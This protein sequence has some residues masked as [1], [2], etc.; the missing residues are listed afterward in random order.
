MGIMPSVI[1]TDK[2]TEF[3]A[4]A[5]VLLT[6]VSTIPGSWV[7][8]GLHGLEP[9]TVTRGPYERIRRRPS[10]LILRPPRE[11]GRNKQPQRCACRRAKFRTHQLQ[12]VLEN[13][14]RRKPRVRI[15]MRRDDITDLLAYLGEGD[16]Q[17]VR[18]VRDIVPTR[19]DRA[20]RPQC[21]GRTCCP[22]RRRCRYAMPPR[23]LRRLARPG[24]EAIP[25]SFQM[26][27]RSRGSLRVSLLRLAASVRR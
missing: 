20:S 19:C 4:D 14:V 7:P 10:G 24:A 22:T 18:C 15:F 25:G 16:S 9:E 17:I 11:E 3:T 23:G 2:G 6:Q 12:R 1:R 5:Q 8:H 27:D 13:A 26:Q 21:S